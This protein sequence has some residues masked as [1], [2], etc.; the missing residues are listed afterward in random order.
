MTF[1][2]INLFLKTGMDARGWVK[3]TGR[4][5]LE[6]SIICR[7]YSS[8]DQIYFY[9]SRSPTSGRGW[10]PL[11]RCRSC[12]LWKTER[13]LSTI[14]DDD[15]GVKQLPTPRLTQH[16]GSRQST[17]S[18][19]CNHLSYQHLPFAVFLCVTTF[20]VLSLFTIKRV[21]SNLLFSITDMVLEQQWRS[22]DQQV[23][24]RQWR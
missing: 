11:S 20:R 7:R 2:E 1:L 12:N 23:G 6:K 24:E 22:T 4:Y 8:P 14:R 17:I 18:S 10:P 3:S 5:W 9:I 16:P 19:A 21:I 13:R 15:F